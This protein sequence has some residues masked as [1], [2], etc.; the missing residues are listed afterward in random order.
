VSYTNT[1]QRYER[2]ESPSV[3]REITIIKQPSEPSF[4]ASKTSF[5]AAL[6]RVVGEFDN[7]DMTRAKSAV[8]DAVTLYTQLSI[9]MPPY[10]FVNDIAL[11]GMEWRIG[12]T[13]VLLI[14]GGDGTVTV[15]RTSDE[16]GYSETM[17]DHAFVPSTFQKIERLLAE[18]L[19]ADH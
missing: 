17:E 8:R 2:I 18:I 15:A 13:G 12:Q 6:A 19:G 3:T 10:F 16:S 4:L 7:G 5:D 1:I 9:A 14:F 11:A